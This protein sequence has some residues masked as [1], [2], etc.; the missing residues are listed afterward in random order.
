MDYKSFEQFELKADGDGSTVTGYG[1]IF[2]NVDQGGDV[3]IEGAFAESLK[4]DR[5]IKML[6]NHRPD[7]PIGLWTSIA[8]D[9][10]GLKVE[11]KIADTPKGNEVKELIKMGAID[12]LSIGYRTIDSDY[13]KD[14]N[15]LLKQVDLW[16]TSIVTFPMNGDAV[17][18]AVKAMDMSKKE[19]ERTLRDAGFSRTV[20]V[21][22]ISGGYNAIQEQSDSA[23]EEL[24]KL[25]QKRAN[26]IKPNSI[27]K[28]NG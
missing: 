8:E 27:E 15:R 6:W 13:D 17:I 1:A 18:D 11:G 26:L 14:G 20:A 28:G 24:F 25:L 3:I 19:L 9:E 21:K 16:E 7:Q 10:K 4:T 23:D 22:L 2:G 5:K 12:S